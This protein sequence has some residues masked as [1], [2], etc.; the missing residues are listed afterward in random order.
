MPHWTKGRQLAT[1]MTLQTC[2][3]IEAPRSS[4]INKMDVQKKNKQ[5]KTTVRLIADFSIAAKKPGGG[6]TIVSKY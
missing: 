2:R 5:K 3:Q 6:G 1:C 4:Q